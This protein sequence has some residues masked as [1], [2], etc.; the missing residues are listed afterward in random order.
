M[1]GWLVAV[2]V[3]LVVAVA[4]L[5]WWLLRPRAAPTGGKPSHTTDEMWWLWQQLQAL[6]PDS[7]L[8]GT[9]ADKPGYHNQRNA[10]PSYDYSV[11]DRPPDDGGPGD[12]CA[13]IDW[14]FYDAQRG[15]YSTISKYTKRLLASAKDL[16]DPRLNGWREFYG[17]AD[18]DSYVEGWDCRYYCAATSDSSHLWHIHISENRDQTRS[19]DNKVALLSVLKGESVADWLGAGAVEGDGAVLLN[20]PQTKGRLDLLYVGPQGEVMHRWWSGGMG[21]IWSGATSVENLGGSI[22]VGTLT[23][24]W[25]P[26]GDTMN[27]AGLG[28]GDANCPEGCGQFWGMNLGRKGNRSG[29]GSFEQTYGKLPTVAAEGGATQTHTERYVPH[30]VAVLAFLVAIFAVVYV[31]WGPE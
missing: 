8:G 25:D 21:T 13:A 18:D 24:A 20:D 14:T 15:D 4:I 10:L 12:V 30:A 26:D 11:C 31:V 27:I 1:N 19:M 17:N 29:W 9:Y 5:L 7:A 2:L 22:H 6:E 3:V 23:A 28:Q 16:D